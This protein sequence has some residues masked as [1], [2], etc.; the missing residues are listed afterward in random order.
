MRPAFH[1]QVAYRP[2]LVPPPVIFVIMIL[3]SDL[4]LIHQ[5]RH[6]DNLDWSDNLLILVADCVACSTSTILPPCQPIS[7]VIL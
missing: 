1:A 3:P 6:L 7:N 5:F 4:R 2:F